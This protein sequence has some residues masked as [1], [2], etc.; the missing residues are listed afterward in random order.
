MP[1]RAAGCPTSQTSIIQPQIKPHPHPT[2]SSSHHQLSSSFI[3]PRKRQRFGAVALNN[4]FAR[5]FVL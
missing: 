1:A 2:T 3:S 5:V 4:V